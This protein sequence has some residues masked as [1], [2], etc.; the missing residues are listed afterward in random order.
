MKEESKKKDRK[1]WSKKKKII[2]IVVSV[3]LLVLCIGIGSGISSVVKLSKEMMETMEDYGTAESGDIEV[4][5]E[6]F[7][8]A[9]PVDTQNL[10]IDYSCELAELYKQNGEAVHAGDVIARFTPV[11]TDTNIENLEQS[12]EAVESRLSLTDKKGSST[13]TAPANG[14]I[15][16]IYGEAGQEVASVM[17]RYGALMLL[18]GDERLQVTVETEEQET[19]RKLAIGDSASIRMN[20]TVVEGK[21]DSIQGRTVVV[22]FADKSDYEID[23]QAEVS[24]KDTMIGTGTVTC[25]LPVTVAGTTGTIRSVS[26][27]KGK[28]VSSGNTLFRL[29]NVDYSDDYMALVNQREELVAQITKAK[30]YMSGYTLLAEKDGIISEMTVSE[31]DS[32]PAGTRFCS[33]MG[34]DQYQVRVEIDELDISRIQVGQEAVV[35]FDAVE[36]EEYSGQVSGVSL[37]GDNQGGVATYTIT[38]LLDETEGILPGL[39]AGAKI[40]TG[41][42]ENVMLA[43]IECIQTIDGEK[44]VIR[45]NEDG[46]LE[47]IAVTLGLVNNTCAE[48]NGDIKE[49]DRLQKMVTMEDIYSQMGFSIVEPTSE[50]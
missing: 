36:N 40:T 35:T 16:A 43:P 22:T 24:V 25:H 30:Q 45:M 7:G 11:V 6:G 2:V 33:I 3:L 46:S 14:R 47:T 15:K 41:L 31:G 12:L 20:G 29:E 32:I 4:V 39:S 10:M 38:I 49:G 5:T 26:T 37:A 8:V 17:Q 18:S 13:I 48:I 50:E 28:Q 19:V 34:N 1:P 42:Q 9:E 44:C 27:E 21:V 23:I